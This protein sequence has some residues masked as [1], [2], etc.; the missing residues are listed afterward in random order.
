MSGDCERCLAAGC[1]AHLAKPI[2]RKQ[3]IETVA[4]Y[5]ASKAQPDRRTDG[6][7]QAGLPPPAEG[8]GISSQFADDPQLADILPGF[9]ERLPGQLE[10]LCKALEEERLEDAPAACPSTQG[11][12]RQLRL[13][14]AQRDGQVA[15]SRGQGPGHGRSGRGAGGGQ[16][17]LRGHPGGLD[18]SHT[19]DR[20][21]MKRLLLVD[22]DVESLA[23]AQARLADDEIE[24]S[25]ATGGR[26]G[27]EAA[28]SQNPD[29]ILLDLDM[30][31]M[32]GFDVCR[33]LKADPELCMIPVLFL[34]G[35]GTP[36]DKV[37]GLDLGAVDYITKPFDDFELRARVRAAMRTKQLQD[38][39]IEHAHIDPLTG[40]PNRRA[41]MDR[42]QMEWA[43]M[44]RHGGKLSFIM[45]DIDYFKRVNDAYGHS[46]GDKVLQEVAR[47]IARQ[48]RESDLPARYG[49][50]E[51]AVVVPD[52]ARIR[53]SSPGRTLPPGDREGRPA[54]QRRIRSSNGE[55]RSGRRGGSAQRRVVGGSR[56][57]GP[58]PGQ[59]R[60][61]QSGRRVARN[62]SHL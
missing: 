53:R 11:R 43:R 22:D 41:L 16:R 55:F 9:V 21:T 36:G 56:G 13:S 62:A 12:G 14:D 58:V 31:D 61:A 20:S 18:R 26:A 39:L 44:Q 30:P 2:D 23:V 29:L 7:A 8:D 60:R 37:R 4:Q 45:A 15:G 57:S 48:C 59:S 34:S 24:I 19:G 27:L 52:E 3:L 50:E 38:L 54:G 5:A 17:N 25:C 28:K 47:T 6:R 10:A 40:L 35:S 46:I 42:L 51:F 49:G 32:S 1:D 33:I